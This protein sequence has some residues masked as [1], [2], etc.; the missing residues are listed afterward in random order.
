[1]EERNV[2]DHDKLI[3]DNTATEYHESTVL[4]YTKALNVGHTEL[5]E[6]FNDVVERLDIDK[7]EGV[8]LENIG[9]IVGQKR[10]VI[11]A[12]DVVFF[13]FQ[14]IIESNS[15]GDADD[16]SLG[17][18][19]R[20]DGEPLIGNKRLI[21]SEYRS[22]ISNRIAKN[23]TTSRP[24]ETIEIFQDLFNIPVIILADAIPATGFATITF[25]NFLSA[26]QKATLLD[27]SI[28]PKTVGVKYFY[29]EVIDPF[30]FL[31]FPGVSPFG[32]ANDLPI[33]G[34]SFPRDIT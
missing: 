25:T 3:F 20:E 27:G 6:V 19:F 33:T 2:I 22:F 28:V 26:N 11:A 9:E 31:G 34:G 18:R 13:G 14:G 1:M 8:G 5:D 30:G 32:D 21:D 17:G 10:T 15:F 16:T 29:N 23:H 4:T 12:S 7:A 24:E